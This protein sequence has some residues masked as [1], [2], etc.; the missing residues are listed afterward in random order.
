MGPGD[1][2]EA[3][4]EG[5]VAEEEEDDDSSRGELWPEWRE[6]R[7][8]WAELDHKL[9][10]VTGRQ[11]AAHCRGAELK[12]TRPLTMGTS[13][14]NSHSAGLKVVSAMSGDVTSVGA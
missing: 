6:L 1:T 10:C 9:H 7:G 8:E 2:E 12:R 4:E 13:D 5:E 3:W 11:E 14:T